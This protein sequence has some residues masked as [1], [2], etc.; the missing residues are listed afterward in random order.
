MLRAAGFH[1]EGEKRRAGTKRWR[2]G[3]DQDV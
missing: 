3:E 2:A 1:L